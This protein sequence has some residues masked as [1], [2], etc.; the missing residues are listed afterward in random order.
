MV[1]VAI[2]GVVDSV[3][4]TVVHSRLGWIDAPIGP[5]MAEALGLPVSVGSHVDAMAAAELLLAR[6]RPIPSRST[7]LYV[8]ARETVGYA[9]VIDDRVYTPASGP[10]TIAGLPVHSKL[11]R[12]S[13]KLESTVSDE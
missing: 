8:Y 7:S 2:G 6:R 5:A 4:G 3:A 12:G 1:G 11:L 13:G 10:G 9:L